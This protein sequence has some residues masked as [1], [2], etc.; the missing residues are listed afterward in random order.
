MPFPRFPRR[1]ALRLLMPAAMLFT[2]RRG[3]AGLGAVNAANTAHAASPQPPAY[4]ADRLIVKFNGG[5]ASFHSDAAH[6]NALAALGQPHDVAATEAIGLTGAQIGPLSGN[7][8]VEQAAAKYQASGLF[9]Y[10]QPDYILRVDP[11]LATPANL[12]NPTN[13][14]AGVTPNDPG[15]SQLWGLNN[16]GQTGGKAD[17]DID[18]PEAWQVQTGS[19]NFVIGVIDTGV[20]YTH[21]DLANNIWINPGELVNGVYVQDGIDNDGNGYVDDIHGWDFV[22]NDNDPMD[23]NGHGTHVS[24]TIAGQG[25]NGIGVTG[26]TGVDWSA[27][28][29]PLKFLGASGSGYTSDAIKAIDYATKMGVKLANNSWGGGSSQALADAI[30][31]AGDKGAL[32]IAAAGN[33]AENNDTSPHYPASYNLSNIISVAATTNTDDLSSF[34]NYGANTVD[35]GAPGSSIY[36]TL[37]VNGSKYGQNYGWLS[38]TSMA[39]PHVTGAA[40]LLWSQHPDWTA[41]QIKDVLLET[42]DPVNA[43]IGKTVSGGRLNVNDALL[44]DPRAATPNHP[45]A[46]A[47]K[48]VALLEDAPYALAAADFGFADP[49][50]APPDNLLAVKIASLPAAGRLTL[51]GLAVAEGQIVSAEDIGA[52]KLVYTPAANASGADYASFTVQVQDDGGF[53]NGGVNLDQ[54]PNTFAVSVA[55]VNDAPGF[56]VPSGHAA[57]ASSPPISIRAMTWAAAWPCKATARSWC[58]GPARTAA[59]STSPWRVTTPTARSTA[60]SASAASSPRPS[61]PA[62]TR[63]SKLPCK[64]TAKSSSRGRVITAA[65]GIWRW[66]A[67]TPTAAWTIVS[68]MTAKP[69]RR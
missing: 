9:E 63:A 15:F 23:D 19:H 32:F 42:A 2:A 39:T 18:A 33:N 31:A 14:A 64:A 45:P 43:L 50:D 29:M 12:A 60:P 6:L 24:G 46:G 52:G 61:A 7:I 47:D 59:I 55:A 11:I 37:P 58:P 17:A 8:T 69:P 21:P 62:T 28:V 13:A 22:N 44:F 66:R 35:L 67:T 65:P 53:I 34:S 30:Q 3:A 10:V 56:M 26:V 16:T 5:D 38:G 1:A 68:R 48:A 41:Q 27:Q 49:N 25:N 54:S 51:A 4:A 20:D 57:T 40:A 36:S